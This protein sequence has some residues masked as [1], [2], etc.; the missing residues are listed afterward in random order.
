MGLSGGPSSQGSSSGLPWFN[1]IATHFSGTVAFINSATFNS[2][3]EFIQG[4]A[5]ALNPLPPSTV[6]IGTLSSD[7]IALSSDWQVVQRDIDQVWQALS[8]AQALVESA[9]HERSQQQERQRST[10]VERT[11]AG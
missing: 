4:A 7:R 5:T 3:V 11:D 6:H 8:S 10:E 1:Y 9:S 2:T